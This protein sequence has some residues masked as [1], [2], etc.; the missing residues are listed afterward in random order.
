VQVERGQERLLDDGPFV[1]VSQAQGIAIVAKRQ[2]RVSQYQ[3]GPPDI[4]EHNNTQPV[5]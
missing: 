2:P 1:H 4:S 3:R 5:E